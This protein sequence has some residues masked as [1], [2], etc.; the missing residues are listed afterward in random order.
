MWTAFNRFKN[1]KPTVNTDW[2]LTTSS[3]LFN[4]IRICTA[5]FLFKWNQIEGWQADG[6]LIPL[7]LQNLAE[8][9]KQMKEF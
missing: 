1:E 6:V 7:R 8:P 5:I 3:S 9:L 4:L 2:S